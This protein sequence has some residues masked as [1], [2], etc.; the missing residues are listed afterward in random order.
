MT[1]TISRTHVITGLLVAVI[2]AL[3]AVLVL[4]GGG[5]QVSQTADRETAIPVEQQS[6]S[7]ERQSVSVEQ[8]SASV[9]QQS[10][11]VEQQSASVEQQSVPV[12]QQSASVEQQSVP[13][14]QQSASVEQQSA[15][16]EDDTVANLVIAMAPLMA[17][18]ERCEQVSWDYNANIRVMTEKGADNLT[19]TDAQILESGASRVFDCLDEVETQVA[20]LEID[21]PVSVRSDELRGTRQAWGRATDVKSVFEQSWAELRSTL[22][23]LGLLD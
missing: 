1:V 4:S 3:A 19:R 15:S 17:M 6:A 14:E 22:V 11:P 8:Q 18:V 7:V 10:V 23:G 12:E 9:E 5:E 2:V 16:V 13:V 21:F 20:Q